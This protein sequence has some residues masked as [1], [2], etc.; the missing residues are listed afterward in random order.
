MTEPRGSRLLS[1]WVPLLVLAG[2][3]AYLSLRW[4]EIPE[5]WVVHWGAGGMPNGWT[6]RTWLG[7]YGPLLGGVALWGVFEAVGVVVRAAGRNKP[8]LEPLANASVHLMRLVMLAIA[9]LMSLL[10]V[11]LPLGPR[12]APGVIVLLAFVLV[13]G[14][15]A[16]GASRAAQAMAFA[17]AKDP[18]RLKGYRGLFYHDPGDPRLFVPKMLGI[19]WTINFA[20]RRAWPVLLLLLGGPLVIVVVAVLLSL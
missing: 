10:A 15:I 12:V 5:R 17:K 19:G 20:H 6:R 18:E 16:L 9:I 8:G 13:W 2:A 14:A 1:P 11:T 3:A 4:D 7:V